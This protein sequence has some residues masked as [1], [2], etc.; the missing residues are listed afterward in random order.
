MAGQAGVKLTE[1]GAT[2]PYGRDPRDRNL[3][4]A[5]SL[6]RLAEIET[7][8]EVVAVCVLRAALAK[9]AS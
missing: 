5:P 9:L 2:Y 6:P 1:A 4:I 3:R 8:M 7:A